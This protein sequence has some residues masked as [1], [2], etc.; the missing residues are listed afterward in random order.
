ML[1]WVNCMQVFTSLI[2]NFSVLFSGDNLHCPPLERPF[3]AKVLSHYPDS[4]PWNPF[5]QNAVCMVS[6]VCFTQHINLV[7]KCVIRL[8]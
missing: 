5:D 8:K 3:K 6:A 4:L 2:T 1:K 7:L